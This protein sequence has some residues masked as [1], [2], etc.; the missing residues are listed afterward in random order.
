MEKNLN[1][2]KEH[3]RAVEETRQI[4]NAM[5]LLSASRM[6]KLRQHVDYNREY[7]NRIR[8]AVKDILSRSPSLEYEY[9]TQR[10]VRRAAYL[11]IAGDKGMAGAYNHNVL[12]L[13]SRII[14]RQPVRP[15]IAT[16][17]ILAT[18]Y[19]TRRG[20]KPD[21]AFP[22]MAQNPSLG[23]ARQVKDTLVA[24][25]DS[26]EVDQVNL[27]YTRFLNAASQYP[28]QVRLLPLS[29]RDYQNVTVEYDYDLDMIYHPSPER[30]F[31]ELAPQYAVGLLFG[32]MAQSY[33]S[34]QSARMN[35]MQ[36]ATKNADELI[37]KLRH[38]YHSARQLRITQE[39]TETVAAGLLRQ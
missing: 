17:G 33:A 36:N 26:G 16:I 30:V 23:N 13:A 10:P 15:Y 9:L 25:Y 38:A 8:S 29:I 24:L 19:F 31:Y 28:R 32:A 6:K 14:D 3:I 35:A 4:T 2:L 12:N 34:E 20:Q 21:H 37:A 18:E 27:I 7:F 5:Y 22:G 1:Q 11:V 39:L